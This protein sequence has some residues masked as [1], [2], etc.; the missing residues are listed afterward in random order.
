MLVEWLTDPQMHIHPLLLGGV[1]NVI[2]LYVVE[3]MINAGVSAEGCK[4][5]GD[6]NSEWES[7]LIGVL[8][9]KN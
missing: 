9:T 4:I 7:G 5:G 3:N 6:R 2:V 8:N 1:T